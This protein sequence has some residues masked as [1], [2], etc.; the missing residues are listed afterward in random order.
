MTIR[1]HDD[2]LER[3]LD[4]GADSFAEL[5]TFY[6]APLFRHC[7]RMLGS[8][9]DAEEAVQ[10][11]LTRAWQRIGT[12]DRRGSFSGWMYRIATNVCIDRLRGRR[13][14]IHPVS[15]GPAAARGSM[16]QGAGADIDWIE[17]VGDGPLGLGEDPASSTV[18]RERI[19]LAF[20]AALHRLSARQ[21]A[22]LLLHDVLEFT[23]DEVAEVLATST[24][25]VN[26]LLYRARE[27]V[28]SAA[29]VV[30][31]NPDDPAVRSL[32]DRYI[33]AWEL[34]DI[35]E[36]L[37]TVSDDVQFSMPP[38]PTWYEG[39]ES[40]GA[41]VETAIFAPARPHGPVLIAGRANG[42]SALGVYMP[43]PD[44]VLVIDGLQ[45]LDIDPAT[46]RI[47]AITSFRDPALAERCGFSSHLDSRL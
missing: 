2:V 22:A 7:Y 27:V 19:S 25:A 16:P 26:S 40:V 39:S 20:V 17:P 4:G 9:Q 10:D 35:S 32:L 13:R 47:A 29:V 21:R 11:T 3:A 37:A 28:K 5:S 12:F 34:A 42:Q 45:V 1:D 43:G 15:L 8:G 44:G 33:R 6:Q 46:N 36:F 24:S 38:L 41:F 30:P 23:H 31:S 18:R 14:R